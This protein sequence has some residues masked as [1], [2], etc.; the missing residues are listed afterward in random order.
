M[1][2]VKMLISWLAGCFRKSREDYKNINKSMQKSLKFRDYLVPLVLSGEKD[3]TWRLF[4]DKDLQTGDK[5]EL[6]NWNSK[7]KFGE[8]ELIKAMEKKMGD[9]EEADF[10]GHE[11]FESNEEMYK[12]Y[13]KYYGDSVGAETLVKI[14]KFRLI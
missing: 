11:R 4:D 5:V 8:A 2:S 1:S 12:T 3:S 14:I 6:I 7:E 10:D 13:R 9:L